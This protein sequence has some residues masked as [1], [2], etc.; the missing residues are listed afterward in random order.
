[1]IDNAQ[2]WSMNTYWSMDEGSGN[3]VYDGLHGNA[4]NPN[5]YNGTIYGAEWSDDV[6]IGW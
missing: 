3:I 1:M 5:N 2:A 6:P 4:S